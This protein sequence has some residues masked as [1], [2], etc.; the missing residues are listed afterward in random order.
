[1]NWD[2]LPMIISLTI[3]FAAVVSPVLVA[4]INGFYDLKKYKL[5][6]NERNNYDLRLKTKEHFDDYCLQL[7]KLHILSSATIVNLDQ[8]A[9]Y[10]KS[11]YH[12]LPYVDME[13]RILMIQ[14]DTSI[15]IQAFGSINKSMIGIIDS[16]QLHQQPTN[17]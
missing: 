1:M 8:V 4:Y 12:L 10:K 17:Q 6:V 15:D 11:F 16:Y 7:G 14:L 13:T 2:N 3:G 9:D 5:E